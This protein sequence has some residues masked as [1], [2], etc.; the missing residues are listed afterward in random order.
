MRD[1]RGVALRP[2]VSRHTKPLERFLRLSGRPKR[3]PRAL[4]AASVMAGTASKA[5][6]GVCA[7][8]ADHLAV[9]KTARF[10]PV[11]SLAG[12]LISGPNQ[13][14]IRLAAGKL[15]IMRRREF[16][17]LLGTGAVAWPLPARGQQINRVHKIGVLTGLAQNDPEAQRRIAVLTQALGEFG[18]TEG[19]TIE[20]VTRYADAKPDRLP[21]LAV[22]LVQQNVDVIV[23]N[24]AEPIEAAR[25]D[26]QHHSHRDGVGRRRGGLGLRRELGAA[27]RQCHWTDACRH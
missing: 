19:Q 11:R 25:M 8:R 21:A 22:E 23:T 15:L 17:T 13:M 12:M 3:S 4:C 2:P 20:L 14:G 18:W 1:R 24:A 9:V 27:R 16:I 5:L 7:R 26:H 6:G 10:E